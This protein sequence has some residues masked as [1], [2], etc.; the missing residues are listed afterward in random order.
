M[1]RWISK[2]VTVASVV[3]ALAVGAGG[4]A[5]ADPQGEG[6]H[7]GHPRRHP[8]GLVHAALGLGSIRAEQRAELEQLAAARKAAHGPVRQANAV[9]LTRLAHQVEQ[10]HIDRAGLADSLGAEQSAAGV[11]RNVEVNTLVRLHLVLSAA[12]RNE[13]VDGLEARLPPDGP[14]RTE[15]ESFR[16]ETFDAGAMVKAHVP[17]EHAIA[18]AERRVPGMTPQQRAELAG[19]LRERAARD[20]RD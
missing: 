7:G 4:V 14:R 2:V 8:E 10:D 3:G 1:N 19:Q 15:L 5:L 17:G 11:A 20:A 6:E 12:Q 16:G 13:L 18:M 9:V